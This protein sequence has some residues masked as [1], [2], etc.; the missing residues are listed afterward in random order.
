MAMSL[1][2]RKNGEGVRVYFRSE[3]YADPH[4][5]FPDLMSR[6]LE[7]T[8]SEEEKK[9]F[10][11]IKKERERNLLIKKDNEIFSIKRV[12]EPLPPMA[13]IFKSIKCDIC[14]EMVMEGKLRKTKKGMVCFSCAGK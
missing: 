11:R 10:N 3:I 8:A 9:L 7:G 12:K 4:K 1:L 13:R 2:N 5:E 6:V 14:S